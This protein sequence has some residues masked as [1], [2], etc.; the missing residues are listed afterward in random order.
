[1]RFIACALALLLTGCPRSPKLVAVTINPE[2]ACRFALDVS[3]DGRDTFPPFSFS[4][5]GRYLV[6]SADAGA[7]DDR[8]VVQGHIWIYDLDRVDRTRIRMH[9][10]ARGGVYYARWSPSGQ[11]IAVVTSDHIETISPD[12]TFLTHVPGPLGMELSRLA[13]SADGN[14]L[15]VSGNASVQYF[16]DVA[17]GAQIDGDIF[18]AKITDIEPEEE[19]FIVFH[20]EG[21]KLHRSFVAP[22]RPPVRRP[23]LVVRKDGTVTVISS[24]DAIVH[25]PQLGA[26]LVVRSS[27]HLLLPGIRGDTKDLLVNAEGF[28]LS[29]DRKRLAFAKVVCGQERCEGS[30]RVM[31]CEGLPGPK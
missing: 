28:R 29:R 21:E 20:E 30:L 11:S 24:H 1:V 17:T 25:D 14:T 31:Q 23:D 22:R 13:F 5:D 4:P 9:G 18:K 8:P 3:E 6:A 7:L 10:S 12:G 2:S 19:G 15:A 16:V 26:R 27:E